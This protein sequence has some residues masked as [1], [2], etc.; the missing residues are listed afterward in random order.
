[1]RW[2]RAEDGS[3]RVRITPQLSRVADDTNVWSETYD[4]EIH[5]IFEVQSEIAS[6]VVEKL[7]VTLLGSEQA[8][9]E[10]RPTDNL[11]AYEAYLKAGDFDG[12]AWVMGD[13]EIVALYE[14]AIALDPAF[15]GAWVSLCTHHSLF[16]S[17]IERTEER[18][19]Q[20]QVRPSRRRSDRS[21][22]SLDPMG[23]RILLL[24]RV[25]AI[26]IE[27]WSS[28][29]PLRKVCPTMPPRRARSAGSF[30]ARGSS[31][32]VSRPSRRPANSTRVT[33]TTSSTLA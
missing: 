12:Y 17:L 7:G 15:L 6:Q 10:E 26:T 27:P 32:S 29:P 2:A 30:A 24:P 5:D 14:R 8:R 31:R 11:E 33:W 9:L 25:S 22:R 1:M 20:G 18:L 21:G 3:G 23:T 16:Y 13:Q 28:S 19:V 4:R